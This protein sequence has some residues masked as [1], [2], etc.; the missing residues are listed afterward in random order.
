MAKYNIREFLANKEY[1]LRNA[2]P[3]RRLLFEEEIVVM[4]EIQEWLKR[5]GERQQFRIRRI[6]AYAGGNY[7]LELMNDSGFSFQT[8]S[9]K[10]G[11]IAQELGSSKCMNIV[12][13][14]AVA[15]VLKMDNIDWEEVI[16]D[17]VP[18]KFLELNLR[19]YRAGLEAAKNQ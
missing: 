12:L 13:F 2:D 1:N 5:A 10:A 16:R 7:C 17:T 15:H 14:G 18:P 3:A 4:G 8:F 9:L 11:D 6:Q 19:A